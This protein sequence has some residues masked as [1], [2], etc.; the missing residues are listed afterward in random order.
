MAVGCARA[1]SGASDLELHAV[2]GVDQPLPV[3]VHGGVSNGAQ[4]NPEAELVAREI[5]GQGHVGPATAARHTP[6]G[7]ALVRV[8]LRVEVAR[9]F[10]PHVAAADALVVHP[11]GH[12]VDRDLHLGDVGVEEV[13]SVPCPGRVRVDEQ[14]QDAF[15]RPALW[16]HPQVQPCVRPTGDGHHSLAH[17]EVVRELLAAVVRAQGLVG[18]GLASNHFVLQLDILE[19][20]SEL[21]AIGP[22]HDLV[23]GGEGQLEHQVIKQRLRVED[24]VVRQNG[25][26][27]VDA[28][29][30]AVDT[31][32]LVFL[33][34]P[35]CLLV[36]RVR[37]DLVQIIALDALAQHVFP[38]ILRE[39]EILEGLVDV[40]RV[41]VLHRG[42]SELDRELVDQGPGHVLHQIVVGVCAGGFEVDVEHEGQRA[43]GDDLVLRQLRYGDVQRLTRVGLRGVEGD[44]LHGPLGLHSAEHFLRVQRKQTWGHGHHRGILYVFQSLRFQ[45]QMYTTVYYEWS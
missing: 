21:A 10:L 43:R 24:A 30:G 34:H 26:C 35:A 17:D 1:G 37:A 41:C 5:L 31:I 45:R 22:S 14:Q 23:R 11:V 36:A 38:L 16:V 18:Q 39:K 42:G 2:L 27:Q 4:V 29:L 3:A 19:L 32:Q 20:V 6:G 7:R 12:A 44:A 13:L 33:V 40:V 28:V 15:E 25:V 9:E 8:P